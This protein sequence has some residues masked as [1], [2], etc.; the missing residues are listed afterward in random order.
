MGTKISELPSATTP[1]GSTDILVVVQ[2]GVTKKA[3]VSGLPSSGGGGADDGVTASNICDAIMDGVDVINVYNP[4]YYKKDVG[5]GLLIPLGNPAAVE[6]ALYGT[7]QTFP[8]TS[9]TGALNV[10]GLGTYQQ[11]TGTTNGGYATSG[12]QFT[13]DAAATASNPYVKLIPVDTVGSKIASSFTHSVSALSDGTDTYTAAV[14]LLGRGPGTN[15]AISATTSGLVLTY[16]HTVNSGNYVINYRGSDGTL[17]TL[18]TTVAPGVGSANAKRIV[19]KAH[20]T[21]AGAATVTVNIAGTTYTITDS[22]F[23]TNSAYISPSIG[24]R[25]VK[26]A[27]TTSRSHIIS[28]ASIALNFL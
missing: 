1:L 23:N 24:Y 15:A 12:Y 22:A 14:T 19:A 13:T 5:A 20:R 8:T 4:F 10:P 28:H 3:P 18:N 7:A 27:G 26:S 2:G 11:H 16:T 21:A 17:K 9:G 6:P 25:I